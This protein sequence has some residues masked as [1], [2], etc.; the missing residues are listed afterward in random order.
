MDEQAARAMVEL[1]PGVRRRRWVLFLIL[2]PELEDAAFVGTLNLAV[3][4]CGGLGTAHITQSH[5]WDLEL[6]ST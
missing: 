4:T 5:S 3:K 1:L 2:H 6:E